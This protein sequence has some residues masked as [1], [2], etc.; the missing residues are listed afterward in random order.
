MLFV[1]Q[2]LKIGLM[3]WW[4]RV[5]APCNN[6][7]PFGWRC[8]LFIFC[9]FIL[10]TSFVALQIS[11]L[12]VSGLFSFHSARAPFPAHLGPR[13]QCH[14]SMHSRGL[15]CWVRLSN[16]SLDR[17]SWGH[18][19]G[20]NRPSQLHLRFCI[21]LQYHWAPFWEK[22]CCLSI[23]GCTRRPWLLYLPLRIS[24]ACF[25]RVW[26]TRSF[27]LSTHFIRVSYFICILDGLHYVFWHTTYL[28]F[29]PFISAHPS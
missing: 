18:H 22:R 11:N 7:A 9:A 2:T 16:S 17:A 20:H 26:I 12:L 21:G 15:G 13:G 24:S 1:S 5:Q 8:V 27:F 19:I 14:S 3:H 23:T 4:T 29:Q 6:K 28:E 25:Y 10:F